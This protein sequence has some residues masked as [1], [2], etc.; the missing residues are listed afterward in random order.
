MSVIIE[1]FQPFVSF[2]QTSEPFSK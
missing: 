2:L 1:D